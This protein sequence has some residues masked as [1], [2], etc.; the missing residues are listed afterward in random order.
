MD[1]TK[2]P[3]APMNDLP[4]APAD[5]GQAT[6]F[7]GAATTPPEATINFEAVPLADPAVVAAN[8][9]ALDVAASVP[10][11]AAPA[12]PPVYHT[13]VGFQGW[14]E[15]VDASTGLVVERIEPAGPPP[16]TP[17]PAEG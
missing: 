11:E 4:A 12:E 1:E 10:A 15:K 17:T 6:D 7:A 16:A 8:A 3:D 5:A 9:E 14:L 2:T 13:R